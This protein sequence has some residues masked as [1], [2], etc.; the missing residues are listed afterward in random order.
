[1][2]SQKRKT[3]VNNQRETLMREFPIKQNQAYFNN[4]SYTP[5]SRSATKAIGE[6]IEGYSKA[7]PSDEYY[8]KLKESG[9]R[10]RSVLARL[11]SVHKESIIFTESAT[12]SINLVAN[13]FDL[14]KEDTVITRGGSSEHPSNY[15]PWKY[16]T[17]KKGAKIVDLETDSTGI[18]DI[19]KL[20]SELKR[21][22]A[23]LVVVSHVLYNLG[24]IL[25][26]EEISRVTHERGALFFLDASQSIANIKVDLRKINADFTAGTA[27]KWICGP[28]GLGFFYCKQ[29]ALKS[30]DPLNFGAN[31]CT[32]TM[33]GEFRELDSPQRLQEGF[34]N[35]SYC[36]GLIAALDLIESFGQDEVRKHN[37]KLADMIIDSLSQEFCHLGSK[38]DSRRTS[39][40][41]LQTKN[42]K[43]IEIVQKLASENITIAEREIK[44]KKIL[45]ISPHYYNDVEETERLVVSLNNP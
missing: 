34:R 43:P 44:E 27:A 15:L 36:E 32:Y 37:L 3:N 7:G 2:L 24:T 39:I 14:S 20:D 6:A 21:T 23:R 26:V 31:A 29:E 11:L 17:S 16:Y 19:S 28:L 18:P 30:L 35:W 8:L 1:M 13:G 40:I 33:D 10:A 5:M 4:A 45:R 41:A 42:K 12:Q 9:N 22:H 25:P 38:D